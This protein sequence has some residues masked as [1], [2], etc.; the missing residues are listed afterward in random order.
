MEEGGRT[1]FSNL[2]K[3]KEINDLCENLDVLRNRQSAPPA[4]ACGA[5]PVL[6]IKPKAGMA[7]IHFPTTTPDYLCLPYRSTMHESQPAVN[8]KYIVQQ[9]AATPLNRPAVAAFTGTL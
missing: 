2:N 5:D 3:G 9:Y 7:V 6:S 1:V 8:D 4:S